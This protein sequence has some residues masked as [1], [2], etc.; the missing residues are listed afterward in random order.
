MLPKIV[1][2]N[3]WVSVN[4][5]VICGLTVFRRKTVGRFYNTRLSPNPLNHRL[6]VKSPR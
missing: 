3:I 6:R 5:T 4:F 1:S 2:V